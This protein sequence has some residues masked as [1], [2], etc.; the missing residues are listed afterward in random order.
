LICS[1]FSLDARSSVSHT[2]I[3]A[4]PIHGES[5]HSPGRRYSRHMRR[6]WS[7]RVQEVSVPNGSLSDS[8]ITSR[9]GKF[10]IEPFLGII[11]SHEKCHAVQSGKGHRPRASPAPTNA[12]TRAEVSSECEG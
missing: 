11:A 6:R 9:Y 2:W 12:C 4:V 7:S 8:H 1:S 5:R 3:N 10:K